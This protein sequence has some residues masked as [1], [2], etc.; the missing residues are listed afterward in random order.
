MKQL[1][2]SIVFILLCGMTTLSIAQ[3][4]S[5]TGKLQDEESKPLALANVVLLKAVDS[6][7][8]TGGLTSTDGSFSINTPGEGR[9]LLRFTAIGFTAYTTE[10]FAVTGSAFTK[11]FGFITLKSEIKSLE[12]VSVTAL[13]PTITQLA[14]KMV[15]SIEGTAMAAGN[16]AFTVLS[17]TPGVFIDA[18][19]NIQLNGRSGIMVM[20]DG[21]QT[22]MSARDLRTMLEAMPA[23][24]LKNIEI[25][26]NP[27]SKYEAEGTSGI[28]NI[29]LKKNTQEGMNGSVT[30]T[31]NNNFTDYGVTGITNMMYKR[32]RWNSILATTSGRYIN[33]RDATF[34]RV[35]VSPAATTYFD[36][37]AESNGL[38]K[39]PPAV[40]F[41]TDY[42]I[43]DKHS[44]GFV[45]R[46]NVWNYQTDFITDTYIGAQ[47]KT[48]SQFISAENYTY[49]S[50]RTFTTNLHYNG[51]LDT[52]GTLLS[53]DLDYV[54]IIKRGYSNFYNYFTDI[55]T[56]QQTQDLLYTNN[57]NGYDV[58]SG[59]ID[60]TRSLKKGRRLEA[61][62][63]ASQVI[64]DNDN[65][66]Y[67]NN[68]S[69]VPDGNRSNHFKYQESIYAAYVTWSGTLSK[70]LSAQAG[71]RLEHTTSMGNSITLERITKREYTNLFPTLFLQHKVSGNYGINYSISRRISRPNYGSL[72]PFRVYRDP[73]TWIEG[74]PFLQP[75]YSNMVSMAHLI[76]KRY[77]ITLSY[78]R[79]EGVI[80][81]LPYVDVANAIT[82]YTQANMS[83]SR[84]MSATAIA[85]L[86]IMKKWDAQ[87]TAVLSYNKFFLNA[88]TVQQTNAQLYFS[89]QS[90]HTILL[91]EAIRMELNLVYRGPAAS[92]LY[93][94]AGMTSVDVGFKRAFLKKKFEAAMNVSDIFKGTTLIR[95]INVGNSTSD[96]DQYFRARAVSFSLTYNFSRGQK[97]EERKRAK[98]EEEDRL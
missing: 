13:R 1:F 66:F 2:A 61:G 18:E 15:V 62:I 63:R 24:Q 46:Y 40:R 49:N 12:N 48:P 8:T 53:A 92:G 98:I 33:G 65:Q 88:D 97:V 67:F 28:L 56:G 73:Y 9:Y 37:V 96:Y 94:Q 34:T 52:S 89:V 84:S 64:S 86:R 21:R 93:R 42:S 81:E 95:K 6:T 7:V 30:A 39:G 79:T 31:Y 10:I 60:F 26:T 51:K 11:D 17:R 74:N 82:V 68:G 54:R 43:N 23:E 57:P 44:V 25:I 47:P 22:F 71:L 91:P 41:G 70:K 36:Q 50:V 3:N 85:P 58:Y 4:S 90:N 55:G 76:Q 87:N 14:D 45:T 80:S 5:L 29:N 72:N 59:K 77:I 20:I 75:Q 69:L 35:F 32:G 38:I 16:T 83:K 19:G 27:S 78:Q